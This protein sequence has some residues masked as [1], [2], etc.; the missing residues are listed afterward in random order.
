MAIKS[1]SN[2]VDDAGD[3]YEMIMIPSIIHNEMIMMTILEMESTIMMMMMMM[4][5]M[6]MT[7]LKLQ[8]HQQPLV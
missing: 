7:I 8:D 1:T 2:N 3:M 6:M 4:M 5:R